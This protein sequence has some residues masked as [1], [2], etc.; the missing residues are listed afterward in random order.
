MEPFTLQAFVFTRILCGNG[1]NND[2]VLGSHHNFVLFGFDKMHF[3]ST[4]ADFGEVVEACIECSI[5]QRNKRRE[6]QS[7]GRNCA[8]G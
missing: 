3:F 1:Q 2:F 6:Y 8:S 7:S 5:K 4:S